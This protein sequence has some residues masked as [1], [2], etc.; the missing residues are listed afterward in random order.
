MVFLDNLNYLFN[1]INNIDISLLSRT[2]IQCML[3]DAFDL[4]AFIFSS[5]LDLTTPPHAHSKMTI[6]RRILFSI[7]H[8]INN[9]T[10]NFFASP[11]LMIHLHISTSVPH[12]LL[13]A[14]HR[15]THIGSGLGTIDYHL[16]GYINNL[17]YYF[18]FAPLRTRENI[19]LANPLAENIM[20]LIE[21]IP[22]HGAL[23]PNGC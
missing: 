18:E 12:P 16:H 22:P 21:A 3:P 9:H 19:I 1:R 8:D 17:H 2:N 10:R 7:N 5:M 14:E 23:Q 15:D 13:L 20:C 4:G 11:R 6:W